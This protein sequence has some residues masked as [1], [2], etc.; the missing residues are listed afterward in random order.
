MPHNT[1]TFYGDCVQMCEDF[2]VNFGD[3]RELAAASRQRPI[4]YRC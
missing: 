3:K 2:G 4:P 1:V